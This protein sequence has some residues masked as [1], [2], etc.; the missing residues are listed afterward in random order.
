[1]AE[2]KSRRIYMYVDIYSMYVDIYSGIIRERVCYY[3]RSNQFDEL[4]LKVHINLVLVDESD[5]G[6]KK[7]QMNL[8]YSLN[9][10]KMQPDQV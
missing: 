9:C 2:I 7:S 6:N 5:F 8:G 1:M 10:N 4:I 3:F